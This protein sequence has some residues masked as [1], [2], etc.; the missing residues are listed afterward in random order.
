MLEM[1]DKY[2]RW[3]LPSALLAYCLCATLAILQKPGLQYDEA[4]LVEG[5]V[6]MRISPREIELPH[7][8]DTWVCP[9]RRCFPLM[10]VRYVGSAK[11]YL[12]LP[13]FAIFGPQTMALRL[14]SMLLG[15]LGIWGIPQ[16]IRRQAG[17]AAAAIVAWILALNPAYVG[18]TVFDNDAI[19]MSMASLGL[20]CLAMCAYLRSRTPAAAFL[21]GAAMALLVWARAN[22]VWM[23]AALVAAAAIVLRRRLRLP[24]SHVTAGILGGIVAGL[25]F[26]V[27]QVS[28][29]VGHSAHIRI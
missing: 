16:L 27:Y 21:A 25:P 22:L 19:A 5:A 2:M 14:L 7:D 24:L 28:S 12:C 1:P 20:L 15:A 4:L 29:T 11:E 23:L 13:V 9:F 18:M 3:A 6:Q 10:T 17:L 8:P 26:L